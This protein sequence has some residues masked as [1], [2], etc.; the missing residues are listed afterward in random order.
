MGKR[1][2]ELI[3]TAFPPL[4]AVVGINDGQKYNGVIFVDDDQ[5]DGIDD[6]MVVF[7]FDNG[8]MTTLRNGC[9]INYEP[10]EEMLF[11]GQL[12]SL[13]TK[14]GMFCVDFQELVRVSRPSCTFR[15]A[16]FDKKTFYEDV[17]NWEIDDKEIKRIIYLFNGNLE[18]VLISD[19][20][21]AL[22]ELQEKF[23]DPEPVFNIIHDLT[24]DKD[25][26]RLS[27]WIGH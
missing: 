14:P 24:A 23:H 18:D 7:I 6:R 17:I 15:S 20:T 2:E 16:T 22:E 21:C 9:C 10:E 11:L 12:L 25:T 19:I 5:V 13:L 1:I 26:V 8:L 27:V 3:E 4:F